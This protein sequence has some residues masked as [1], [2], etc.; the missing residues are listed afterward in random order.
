MSYPTML[1]IAKRTGTDE[2]VGL[3]DET[4]KATPEVRIAAARTISGTSY[5]TKIRVGL[6]GGDYWRDA[7]DGSTPGKQKIENR[8]IE[9]FIFNPKWV[10][11]KAVA[12]DSEDGP[13]AYIAEEAEAIT[14]G[15]MQQLGRQFYYG[16][17]ASGGSK[18]S[19]GLLDVYDAANMEVDAGGS[20]NRSSVWAV[21]WGNKD[22]QWV[23]GRNGTFELTDVTTQQM[24][25]ENNQ[26]MTSYIQEILA[27]IG[28][29]VGSVYSVGRIK[30]V[31]TTSGHELTDDLI[32]ELLFKFPAGVQPDV[33]LMN[34]RSLQLLRES[35]QATNA[36]GAPAPIPDSVGGVPIAVTDSI[37]N[38]E[39]A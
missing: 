24:N 25:G 30:N 23:I 35:R 31:D 4:S 11:D 10:C 39:A 15:A 19:P 8:R 34:P 7:N 16:R 32:Y 27:R 38:D 5:K 12:D 13:V 26:P 6:P 36:T 21:K 2:L 18:G 9:T 29:Q 17:A 14:E 22:V 20:T 3:I 28:V 33:L 1:D 37:N